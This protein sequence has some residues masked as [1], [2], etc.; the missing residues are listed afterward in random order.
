M[1]I[2]KKTAELLYELEYLIG[3]ECYNPNSYDG[4]TGEEGC[5]FR[6]P[7]WISPSTEATEEE[8][9][10]FWGKIDN[11]IYTTEIQPKMVT[12]MRYKFGSNHLY[13][14]EG[15]LNVLEFLENRYDIDF[16]EMEKAKTKK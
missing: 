2:N 1:K 6:Y 11:K 9:R 14:G 7:V 5:S 8:E 4:F 15:L 12:T 16:N 10:K 13:I 3:K